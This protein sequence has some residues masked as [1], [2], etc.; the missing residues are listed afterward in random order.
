MKERRAKG[1]GGLRLVKDEEDNHGDVSDMDDAGIGTERK[2]SIAS[3]ATDDELHVN[4]RRND[5][6]K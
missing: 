4:L 5:T 1:G 6:W 2:E 3:I